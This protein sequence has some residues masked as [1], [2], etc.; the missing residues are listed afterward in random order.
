[1]N[2]RLLTRR[3]FA[4]T[5]ALASVGFSGCVTSPATVGGILDT[6]THFYKEIPRRPQG[7]PWPSKQIK[8]STARFTRRN[9]SRSRDRMV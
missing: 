1:M 4:G 5:L 6:H 9:F 8:F 7:V 2:N 3:E